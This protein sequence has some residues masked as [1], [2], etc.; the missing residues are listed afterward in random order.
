[1]ALDK[2]E[3]AEMEMFENDIN[4]VGMATNKQGQILANMTNMT[5]A[6]GQMGVSY[7]LFLEC[8]MINGQRFKDADYVEIATRLEG[9]N[10]A[11]I[12]MGNLKEA[13]RKVFSDNS[14]DSAKDWANSLIWD[15]VERV[16]SLF[17]KYFGVESSP[18]ESACSM[19]FAT[20]MAGRLLSPGVQ[21]DMVPVLIGKQ[22]AGKT[23]SVM[24]LAP[25]PDT[26]SEIDLGNTRDS[27][28]GRQLRGKLIC[29]LGELKGL[30][31]RDSEWIKSWITRSH[32]EWIPKYV[33]Y[34]TIMPRRCVFIGTSNEQEFLVDGT[35]N[36]RW[37]P[38]TVT[39]ECDPDG[40]KRDC[41][42]LWAE[43]VHYFKLAGVA[44]KPAQELALDQHADHMVKDDA[45]LESLKTKYFDAPIYGAKKT[46]HKMADMCQALGLGATPLRSEQLRVGDSLRQMGYQKKTF[47]VSGAREILW[48]KGVKE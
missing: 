30:K 14:F 26:Y 31:S 4:I 19:Y 28:M 41:E 17:A 15:G 42:Q 22:G 8:P 29:E 7:D 11:A 2:L 21:A 20:A 12:S 34:A 18:Y 40:V 27:D 6:V 1:M 5:R 16:D 39:G 35:G 45:M 36:R 47:R 48:F 37:L 44:W 3:K 23:R 24:A 43:A 32:E 33:E 25:I 46:H 10:F 13:T 38:M 9:A